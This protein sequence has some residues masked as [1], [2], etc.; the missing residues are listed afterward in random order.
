MK[1]IERFALACSCAAIML[2]PVVVV[3]AEEPIPIRIG[4]Q[5]TTTVTA[6]VSHVFMRT[7]ILARNGLK[8]DVKLFAFGPAVNEALVSGAIDVGFIGDMPSVSLAAAN[9]PTRVIARQSVFRGALMAT[10][11]SNIKSV[12]DLK[13][14]QIYGPHGSSVF[15]MALAMIEQ[16]G[17]KP[18]QDAQLVHMG[19]ADLADAVNSGRIEAFFIWDPWVENFVEKGIARVLAQDVGLTMVTAMRDDF[20]KAQPGAAERFLK[21]HKEALLFAAQNQELV[22]GWFRDTDAARALSMN[23]VQKATAYDP[24][25]SAKAFGDVRMT[26]TDAELERYFGIAKRA[27]DLKIFPRLAPVSERV[28]FAAAKKLD[29]NAWAFDVKSVKI[30]K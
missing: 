12:A 9:A 21:A 7:D 15:L 25:W 19:F 3:A 23:V 8:G 16:A 6:Q 22:N 18:A 17:L 4:G 10:A 29:T 1:M 27:A 26:F 20:M 14:K 5:P 2:G 28:D 30:A 13:G 24:Q 11:K